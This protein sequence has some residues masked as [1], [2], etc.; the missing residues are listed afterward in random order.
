MP[1]DVL[2]RKILIHDA[3][4][5]ARGAFWW[6]YPAP[7]IGEV[8]VYRH[9]TGEYQWPAKVLNLERVHYQGMNGFWVLTEALPNTKAEYRTPLGNYV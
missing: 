2:G 3:N 7:K 5:P 1:S 6:E 4:D 8:V 9:N